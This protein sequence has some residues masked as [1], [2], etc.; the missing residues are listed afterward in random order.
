MRQ[1][2]SRHG[3]TLVELLTV[4]AIISILVSLLLP[5]VQ[6]AREAANRL[7]CSN[8][9]RQIGIAV[10]GYETAL[11]VFPSA[12]M[13]WD[14]NG[15][16]HFDTRSTFSYLLQYLE[17]DDIYQTYQ[18]GDFTQNYNSSTAPNNANILAAQNAVTT[19]LCPSN[20]YRQRSGLDS[21]SYG[22]TDYMPLTAAFLNTNATTTVTL[23]LTPGT[24]SGTYKPAAADLGA[25][26]FPVAGI[27]VIRDG[28]SNTMWL[29]EAVGRS[30]HFFN[31]NTALYGA[32]STSATAVKPFL[33]GT[34][35]NPYTDPSGVVGTSVIG[36]G[37]RNTFRWAEP[38]SAAPLAA[39]A[40]AT[41]GYRLIN[42]PV[43][44]GGTTA[45][46]WLTTNC[47]PNEQ[48][49]SFHGGGVNC[50]FL[51]GHVTYIS[52]DTTAAVLRALVTSQEGVPTGFLE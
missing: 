10:I 47:G 26:R 30:E 44:L 28:F 20:F 19:Y 38:A 14:S 41:S 21:Q 1:R 8:N 16:I 5:A 18:S 29:T 15:D 13:G 4:I 11:R 6:R 46:S 24:A 48:P 45:C 27:E 42:N 31:T 52:D 35:T 40:G 49:F 32:A 39:P 36:T 43:M 51:D 50:L 12:G 25:F 17:R 33:T 2:R 7:R 37:A 9:M 3:F 23:R 34:L 22:M